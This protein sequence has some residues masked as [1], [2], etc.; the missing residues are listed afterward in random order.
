MGIVAI[1]A[2]KS[3]PEAQP[4]SLETNPPKPDS[5]MPGTNLSKVVVIIALYLQQFQIRDHIYIYMYRYIYDHIL[6]HVKAEPIIW[7]GLLQAQDPGSSPEA[8]IEFDKGQGPDH[9]GI[10]TGLRAWMSRLWRR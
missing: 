10:A 9:C 3:L 7:N 1:K 8:L 2:R 6:E 5:S 4:T